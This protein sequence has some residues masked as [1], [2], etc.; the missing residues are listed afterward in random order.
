MLS[1]FHVYF[2]YFYIL[3]PLKRMELIEVNGN[4]LMK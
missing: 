1:G 2:T 4:F 3:I